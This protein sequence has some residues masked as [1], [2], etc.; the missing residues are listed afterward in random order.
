MGQVKKS[1]LMTPPVTP[2]RSVHRENHP[3]TGRER[4]ERRGG[5]ADM[6]HDPG[7][8]HPPDPS[9]FQYLFQAGPEESVIT[10][11]FYFC[12]EPASAI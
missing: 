6:S 4:G 3:E 5:A 10:C 2:R 1:G 9:F 8:H 7:Y 11:F 12:T